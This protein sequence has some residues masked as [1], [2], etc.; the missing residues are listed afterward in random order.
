MVS[1][2]NFL[3]ALT[4]LIFVLN[5][6]AE[7]IDI[8]ISYGGWSLSPFIT[9]VEKET[10][11]IIGDVL[12]HIIYTLLPGVALSTFQS[13]INLSSSGKSLDFSLWYKVGQGKFSLGLKGQYYSFQLPYSLD[14]VQSI[15][16]L[17]FPLIELEAQAEGNINLQSIILSPL[18]RWTTLSGKNFKLSLYGG[19]AI[20]HYNGDYILDGN[21][22]VK[23]PF[24]DFEFQGEESQSIEEL[25][26]WS[27]RIPSWMVSP[28]LGM[29]MQYKLTKEFGLLLDVSLSHGFFFSAGLFFAINSSQ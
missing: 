28:S 17:G 1:K 27:D 14:S 19:F 24:G 9:S 10:E 7:K 2:K 13:D 26:K 6:Q 8:Q 15:S 21:V 25:R 16:F 11:R 23:S 4:V 12:Y 3:I 22:L 29:M 20:F 18:A 5:L